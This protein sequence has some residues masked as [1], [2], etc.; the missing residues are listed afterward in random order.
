MEIVF[1]F[2]QPTTAFIPNIPHVSIYQ[3]ILDLPDIQATQHFFFTVYLFLSKMMKTIC[4][5]QTVVFFGILFLSILLVNKNL[6]FRF[7]F[8]AFGEMM[9]VLQH[10]VQEWILE[11][12]FNNA[13]WH[14]IILECF[15]WFTS[16]FSHFPIF[17]SVESTRRIL[18]QSR[19]KT[20]FK[21]T[22][23]INW[24][25]IDNMESV[26]CCSLLLVEAILILWL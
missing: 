4:S 16:C 17:N 26:D 2:F 25:C 22:K 7:V 3:W 19:K 1:A 6:K 23:E 9:D 14:N 24:K 18:K 12:N 8:G 20:I 5:R 11:M 15:N 13:L 10:H 21:T